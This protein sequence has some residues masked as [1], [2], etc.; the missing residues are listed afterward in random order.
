M[1]P[2][3]FEHSSDGHRFLKESQDPPLVTTGDCGTWKV[4]RRTGTQNVLQG[5]ICV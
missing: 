4:A 2:E 5:D 3:C 1:S